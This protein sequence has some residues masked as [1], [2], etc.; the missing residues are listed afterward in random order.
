MKF[1]V[2]RR[3]CTTCIYRPE[4]PLDLPQLEAE[5]AD[6]RMKDHFKSFRLC[7]HSDVACCNVFWSRHKDHFDT[8]QLAQRLDLVEFV[9]HDSLK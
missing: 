4:S 8:G 1:L 3:Q 5:I 7:H 2:Q 9:D 6:P